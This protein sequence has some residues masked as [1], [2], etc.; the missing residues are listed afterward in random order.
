YWQKRIDADTKESAQDV[1]LYQ[2]FKAQ[3][4]KTNEVDNF[5]HSRPVVSEMLL[6]L[7]AI[8][9]KKI[10]FDSLDFREGSVSIKAT[11]K[12]APDRAAGDA[13]GYEK[14]IKNDKELG[15]LFSEVNLLSMVTNQ[16][17]G[18]LQIEIL[19]LYKKGVRKA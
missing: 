9:P 4:A 2:L 12:G 6:R 11:I 7:G 13:S 8:T 5:I 19:C 3:E 1:A 16:T 18:R 14:L 10:A 17:S 15:P